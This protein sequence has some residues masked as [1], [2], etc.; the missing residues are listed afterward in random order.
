MCPFLVYSLAYL[1]RAEIIAQ[2]PSP[3]SLPAI[4][5]LSVIIT[6]MMIV[7][8]V[9]NMLVVIAIA[10]EHNLTTVQN[11]F[12]ASLAMA[13]MLIGLIVMPFSL[14]YELMGYWMF[15]MVWCDVHG[16]LDVLLCTSSIMNICLI[17]SFR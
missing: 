4:V 15:G 13:D 1:S 9:G 16:A 7:I 14:S 2:S 11:W 8:V 12:I 3:H 17:R 10:T 5:I 6:A